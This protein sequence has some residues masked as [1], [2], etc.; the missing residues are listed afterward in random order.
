MPSLQVTITVRYSEQWPKIMLDSRWF[1]LAIYR[2]NVTLPKRMP[3]WRGRWFAER[4][5]LH[6]Y[7]VRVGAWEW[8]RTN[9][10]IGLCRS[11]GDPT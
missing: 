6:F 4:E 9:L 10:E 1:T 3:N 11:E 5:G 8:L 7:Y 2:A